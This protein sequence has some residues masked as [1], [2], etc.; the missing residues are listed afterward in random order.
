MFKKLNVF[1]L[2]MITRNI[3]RLIITV[4]NIYTFLLVTLVMKKKYRRIS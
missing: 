4:D 3:H 1:F 2:Y